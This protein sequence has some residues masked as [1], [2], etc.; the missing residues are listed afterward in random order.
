MKIKKKGQVP[1]V[2]V[3][4]L[5]AGFLLVVMF[6]VIAPRGHGL[7]AKLYNIYKNIV[8]EKYGGVGEVVEGIA[9]VGYNFENGKTEYYDGESWIVLEADN[10]VVLEEKKVNGEELYYDLFN[11]YYDEDARGKISLREKVI[12]NSLNY[13][14]AFGGEGAAFYAEID[15]L[16]SIKHPVFGRGYVRMNLFEHPVGK[17]LRGNFYLDSLNKLYFLSKMP[18]EGFKGYTIAKTPTIGFEQDINN[19]VIGVSSEASDY[20]SSDKYDIIKSFDNV[21]YGDAQSQ[22]RNPR[23]ECD[24]SSHKYSSTLAQG[25]CDVFVIYN[26]ERIEGIIGEQSVSSAFWG[27]TLYST[28]TDGEEESV[29]EIQIDSFNTQRALI[30]VVVGWRDS[31]FEKPVNVRYENG[32]DWYCAVKR[33]QRFY[34]DLE[35]PVSENEVCD[36]DA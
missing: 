16:R 4:V 10:E 22:T 25:T 27:V 8:P 14:F 31:V 34:V 3:G 17:E 35:K 20:L 9:I 36:E 26:N 15:G 1:W 29:K 7:G 21:K 5:L 12:P 28:D 23:L 18:D 19:L 13:N 6:F 2:L 11:W 24:F 30:S 33:G 32:D